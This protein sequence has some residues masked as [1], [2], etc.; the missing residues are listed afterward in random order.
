[1][2][3][4]PKI[5]NKDFRYQA[6][7]TTTEDVVTPSTGVLHPAGAEVIAID[8]IPYD[9]TH[10]LLI[11]LPNMTALLLNQSYIAWAASQTL[12]QKEQFLDSP[13]RFLPKGTINPK[14]DAAI[15][16]LLEQ[17][18]VAIVFAFTAL[19]SFANESIP[20]GYI[21]RKV[22]D[23][24]RCTEEFTKGQAEILSLDTKL[25]AVLPPIFGVKSPKGT[26]VWNR[27]K[28]IKKLRDR[29][30][31]P[32]SQDRRPTKSNEETIWK[33]LLDKTMPNV[34]LEAKNM[35]GYYLNG[36]SEPPR[37]FIKF[38]HKI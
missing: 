38:P 4:D 19:E 37:W 20:E 34:A 22:R 7:T 27:Y 17:R 3:E 6:I 10:T 24:N 1:M 2:T 36:A 12:L 5:A 9:A 16:S 11:S 8:L 13:S 29:I 18:M 21:F 32:K 31:H 14:D 15:F 28:I 35:I 33:E 30:I 25:D 26:Y 23:D